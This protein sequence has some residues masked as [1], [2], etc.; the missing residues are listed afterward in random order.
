MPAGHDPNAFDFGS[1]TAFRALA[2]A[3]LLSRDPAQN[4]AGF[5][6]GDFDLNPDAALLADPVA[7][8]AAVLVPVLK[9]AELTLLLTERTGHLTKHAGQ[10]AFP[11]GRIEDTDRGSLE[12]ALREADEEVGLPKSHAEPLGFLEPYRTGTGFLVTPVVALVEPDFVI[13]PNPNEVASVFEVPLSFL[14]NTGNHRIDARVW[15]GAKRR[16][17]AMPYGERYIWGA[18]AGII[19]ALHRRLFLI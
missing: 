4:H 1:E 8:P 13:H 12:A 6:P 16:Y 19:R 7:I 10:I 14:M 9:R 2:D 15:R 3:K 18:T 5:T 17:Y 11:G